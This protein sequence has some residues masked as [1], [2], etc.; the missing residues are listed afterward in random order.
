MLNLDDI[1]ELTRH[2]DRLCSARDWDELLQL[3]DI[4]VAALQRGKQLWSVA[5]HAE[6]R[7]ALEAPAPWAAQMLVPGTGRPRSERA[8]PGS[9]R[10]RGAHAVELERHRPCH[11]HA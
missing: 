5:A 11:T 6:Y 9:R 4:C 3:R 8:V 2:V 7:L 1:D 10:A